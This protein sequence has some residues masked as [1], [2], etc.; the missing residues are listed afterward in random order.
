MADILA[1]GL[2]WLTGQLAQWASQTVIYSRGLDSVMVPAT[3]GQKLLRLVDEYGNNSIEWTDMDFV[4]PAAAL[5]FT[6]GDPIIPQRGDMIQ[7]TQQTQ[8]QTFEVFPYGT[9]A[10]WR[11]SDPHQTI[12]RI[13]TKLV[14]TVPYGY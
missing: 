10:A 11:W 4:I 5:Y 12:F 2:A 3:F 8:L 1:D 13:H 7:I 14:E 9:D 6:Y